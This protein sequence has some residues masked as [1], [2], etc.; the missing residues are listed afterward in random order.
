MADNEDSTAAVAGERERVVED[1]LEKVRALRE[2]GV[3]PFGYSYDPTHRSADA[4]ELFAAWEAGERAEG[5]DG[6]AETLRLAGRVVAKR[7]MGKSTFIHLADRSGRIQL[8]F[9]VND[10]GEA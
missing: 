4:L 2:M 10:L 6:P 5:A 8:Y 9:R 1:R 3:E 7:V